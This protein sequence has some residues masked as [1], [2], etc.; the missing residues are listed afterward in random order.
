MKHLTTTIGGLKA[1]IHNSQ[2]KLEAEIKTIQDKQ[3]EMKPQ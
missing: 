1:V 3:E 2:A